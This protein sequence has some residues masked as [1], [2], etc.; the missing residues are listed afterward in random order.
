[1]F[2]VV[3]WAVKQML[4][5]VLQE[6]TAFSFRENETRLGEGEEEEA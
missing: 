6:P 1:M 5:N 3:F 4:T 2:N